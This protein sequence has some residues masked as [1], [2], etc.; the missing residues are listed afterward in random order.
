MVLID[1]SICSKGG[2]IQ[3]ALSFIEN[4][5]LDPLFEVVCVVNPEIDKQL[6]SLAKQS[7]KHYYIENIEPIYNKISQGKRIAKIEKKYKPELVFIIFGPSYWR[8]KAPCLQGFALPLMVYPETQD[9]VYK[10]SLKTKIYNKI[11]NF[12][13]A[14]FFKKNADY[15]V[16]ET[17]TFKNRLASFLNFDESKIFVVENSFNANFLINS[18]YK[19]KNSSNDILNLLIP[20][21]YYPHKNLDIL[22]EVASILKNEFK[23]K[24]K[25]NFLI[26]EDSESWGNIILLAN[27]RNVTE[28]FST[29]GTV[30]N[31]KMKELYTI[32]DFVLLPTLAEASTAVYPEAFISQKVLLTSDRDFARELCGNAAIFFDP[33]NPQDIA[34]KIVTTF[35]DQELQAKLIHNGLERVRSTYLTPDQKWLKQRNMLLTLIGNLK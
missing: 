29:Y 20:S 19:I 24:A 11:L 33:L 30:I 27:K 17:Q 12:Y 10:Y 13:K 1:A 16:V 26:N 31:A 5:A 23:F 9:F 2:G 14:F 4:I 8:S 28:C 32:N 15:A 21:A 6:S 7:I 25:F 22:I 34:K 3:V 35:Q 18:E